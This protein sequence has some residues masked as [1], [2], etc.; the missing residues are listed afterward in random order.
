MKVL[1]KLFPEGI[2]TGQVPPTLLPSPPNSSRGSRSGKRSS[3]V[4]SSK[5]Q[6]AAAVGTPTGG[7]RVSLHMGGA[8]VDLKNKFS[9]E[10]KWE[11]KKTTE[12]YKI[13]V[14]IWSKSILS[15]WNLL[16][17]SCKPMGLRFDQSLLVGKHLSF[18]ALLTS[19]L[20]PFCRFVQNP[21]PFRFCI[22]IR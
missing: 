17:C 5:G 9:D 1:Y 7:G 8:G 13:K 20:L 6:S 19:Q 14:E 2:I 11:R 22:A 10:G 12:L 4:S 3:S 16:G 21:V 18:L 15:R